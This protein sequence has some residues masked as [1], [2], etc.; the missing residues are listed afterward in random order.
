MPH[1][2]PVRR[3]LENFE[4]PSKCVRSLPLDM[5]FLDAAREWILWKR[6]YT[7]YL[8][9]ILELPFPSYLIIKCGEVLIELWCH[10]EGTHWK[11]VFISTET[12]NIRKDC[13]SPLD[14]GLCCSVRFSLHF[15]FYAIHTPSGSYRRHTRAVCVPIS[16][17]IGTVRMFFLYY[18]QL[19]GRSSRFWCPCCCNC[20]GS[21]ARC[22]EGNRLWVWK[23]II[24]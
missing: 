24:F 10:F 23:D 3:H 1:C 7:V 21:G 9:W 4:C 20:C 15:T 19:N 2:S 8:L 6:H 11:C 16:E 18:G 13:K 17:L 5:I 12:A 22:L 14:F